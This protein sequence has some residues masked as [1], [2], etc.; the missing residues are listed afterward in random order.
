MHLL[1]DEEVGLRPAEGIAV[2]ERGKYVRIHELQADGS[3]LWAVE[4]FNPA[5]VMKGACR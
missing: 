3:W 4:M 2:V 5:G 1:G